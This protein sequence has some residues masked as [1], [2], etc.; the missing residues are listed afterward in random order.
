M[1]APLLVQAGAEPIL[2]AEEAAHLTLANFTLRGG[3]SGTA[4]APLLRLTGIA[5]LDVANVRLVAAAGMAL[6]VVRCGGRIRDCAVD[7]ADIGMQALD[8]TGLALTGNDIRRCRNNGL[9]VWTSTK[10]Y[11]GTQVLGNRIAEIGA[12]AGGSGENGNGINVFRAAGVVV[13]NNVARGCAF[14]GIRA[15]AGVRCRYCVLGC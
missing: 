4:R 3:P 7:G 14:S 8:S 15:N 10:R 2:V 5:R 12:E 9:Q 13:A 11:D 6:H 1:L